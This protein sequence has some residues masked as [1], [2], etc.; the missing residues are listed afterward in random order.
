MDLF[1]QITRTKVVVPGR[2]P[3]LLSRERLL[4]ALYELLD[5]H[6][7]TIITAPAGYGKTSLLVDAAQ[8]LTIPLCWYAL[9]PLDQDPQRFFPYFIAAITQRFPNFG[10]HSL[11][12]LKNIQLDEA[13]LNQLITA[14]VNEIYDQIPEY[15]VVVLD[16]FHLVN[17]C[18]SINY[19]IN[20]FAQQVSENCRLVIASRSLIDLFDL[21][22]MLARAQVGGL[23]FEELAFRANEI[24]SLL[25]KTQQLMMTEGEAE[26]LLQE[27]EGWV[28][29]VL[30]S[31][32]SKWQKGV[33]VTSRSAKVA[34]VG[35]YD[36]LA[37]QVLNQQP[38]SVR[39]FL[40]HSAYFDEFDAKLCEQVL[41]I[42]DYLG[43]D[44]WSS[45]LDTVLQNN[46]F[47]LTVNDEGTWLRYHH[48]F[49]DFLQTRLTQEQPHKKSLILHRLAHIYAEQKNWDKA[50][51]LYESFDE[52]DVTADFIEMAGLSLFHRGRLQTLGQWIEALPPELVTVRPFLLALQGITVVTVGEVAQGL[53]LL[54]Q[55]ETTYR[56]QQNPTGLARALVWRSVAH[57]FQASYQ[58]A[59]ADADEAL[60]LSQQ[61]NLA[62]IQAEALRAKG[63]SLHH[64]GRSKEAITCWEQS[65]LAYEKLDE[66]HNVAIL[67]MELGMA[68]ESG[69]AYASAEAVYEKARAYWKK[70][71]NLTWL[72][73][74][75]NN[76]GV[77]YH[78][79][80]NYEQAN[81]TLQEA[82]DCARQSANVYAE[83]FALTSLGD[84]YR[85]LNAWQAAESAYQQAQKIAQRF[86]R[87]YLGVAQAKLFRL[88]GELTQ[89]RIRLEA[90]HAYVQES[91][92]RYEH[93]LY[94]LE[95]ACLHLAENNP[96][97]AL[98]HFVQALAQFNS[99]SHEAVQA[100]LYLASAHQKNLNYSASSVYLAKAFE[101]AAQLESWH[102]L[103]VTGKQLKELVEAAT[104]NPNLHDQA[105]R[106]LEKIDQFEQMLPTLYRRLREKASAVRFSPPKLNIQALGDSV[107]TIDNQTLTNAAWEAQVARDLFF[108]LLA[109]PEGLNKEA[110]GTI[111]WPDKPPKQFKLQFK[112]TIY[113]LRRALG[114]EAVL[115]D[116]GSDR[117][118]FNRNLDYEYDVESFQK[119]V[120]QARQAS[121][122]AQQMS[123]YQRVLEFYKGHYLP[124]VEGTWAWAER[125]RLWLLFK[126]A[127]LQLAQLHLEAGEYEQ[128]LKQCQHLLAKDPCL[129]QAHRQAM[130]AHA[131][132]GNRAA[133][134]RQY[135][136]CCDTLLR[137]VNAPPSSQTEALYK[138][139]LG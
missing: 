39:N 30:L 50:H 46:L 35:L 54:T 41:D 103:I 43:Y 66:Q 64:I 98:D 23:S 91:D 90:A 96:Q 102:A 115:L 73:N 84:L 113:R 126:E 31:A 79:Q 93:G 89:A 26:A 1:D 65:L 6:R 114:T 74:L 18:E 42:T 128:V 125:E 139:L 136:L 8:K 112:S 38:D 9:D 123:A 61:E 12:I 122:L 57:R 22:L 100:H 13:G 33:P 95:V 19:F 51:A 67:Q 53:S 109:H 27:T 129:E 120:E 108:C 131:G 32:Q 49:Q 48:L 111:F 70:N 134:V 10:Q 68:Y 36:Y 78:L 77:L 124:W 15:F 116:E 63:T 127:S 88:K 24:Q 118:Y 106:L 2:R 56:R 119:A 3:D 132:L 75:L 92:S 16:D 69:G 37:Q 87:L 62:V 121:S 80:G 97:K 133:V 14:L 55:A 5:R 52:P 99:E 20:Q 4:E 101:I 137:E 81:D 40:L 138:M 105:Q 117:Y 85:D 76:L 86:L 34:G 110:I 7:L 47:V 11:A 17:D 82:L 44:T 83:A 72:A 130:Q 21:P 104:S 59:L 60:S 107:V 28:T 71:T 25:L 45:L 94:Q 29:G 58:A 135:E